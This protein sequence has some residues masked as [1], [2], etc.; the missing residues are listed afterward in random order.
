MRLAAAVYRQIA[1]ASVTS[2]TDPC[3]EHA[4]PRQ[5]RTLSEEVD[6]QARHDRSRC[7]R[8]QLLAGGREPEFPQCAES[9]VLPGAEGRIGSD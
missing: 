9:E 1:S 6:P 8:A 5:Y 7:E 3:F 4:G 2:M